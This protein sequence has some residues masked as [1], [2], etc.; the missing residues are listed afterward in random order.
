MK[1]ETKH[2]VQYMQGRE[3]LVEQD[4]AKLNIKLVRRS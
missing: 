4:V 2:I 1:K 3:L